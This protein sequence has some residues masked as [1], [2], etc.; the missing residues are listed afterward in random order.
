MQARVLIRTFYKCSRL[1]TEDKVKT[2]LKNAVTGNVENENELWYSGATNRDQSKLSRRPRK[3]PR[4][5]S[6]IL[7][8][9]N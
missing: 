1:R 2:L 5:T 6:I 4:E 3:D 8:P 9:G 7:F